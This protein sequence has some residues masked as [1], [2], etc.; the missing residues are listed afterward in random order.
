MPAAGKDSGVTLRGA[1]GGDSSRLLGWLTLV[2]DPAGQGWVWQLDFPFRLIPK[3]AQSWGRGWRRWWQA[4]V[5]WR[6]P[7]FLP[8]GKGP[9]GNTR[10]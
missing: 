5:A 2:L 9:K 4:K 6:D 7:S 3:W 1:S 8:A 10:G